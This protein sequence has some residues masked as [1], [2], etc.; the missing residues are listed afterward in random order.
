MVLIYIQFSCI[1]PSNTHWYVFVAQHVHCSCAFQKMHDICVAD[2]SVL[3]LLLCHVQRYFWIYSVIISRSIEAAD[4]TFPGFCFLTQHFTVMR[5]ICL[6]LTPYSHSAAQ[7]VS[8]W[9]CS[10][11]V[12]E[13]C[14]SFLVVTQ[15]ANRL[16]AIFCYWADRFLHCTARTRAFPLERKLVTVFLGDMCSE[17]LKKEKKGRWL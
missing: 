2:C 9:M 14:N 17:S 7:E 11:L 13:V 3:P 16:C 12:L 10:M 5:G 6:E 15:V 8:A 4:L 1:K